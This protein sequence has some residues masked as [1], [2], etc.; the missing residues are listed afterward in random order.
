KVKQFTMDVRFVI[1]RM[2]N[3]ATRWKLSF[4][5]HQLC[6]DSFLHETSWITACSA[7]EV[8]FQIWRLWDRGARLERALTL[9]FQESLPDNCPS[10]RR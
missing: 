8:Q 6:P 7:S 4:G 2:S 1:R 9:Y 3:M 5:I 10:S